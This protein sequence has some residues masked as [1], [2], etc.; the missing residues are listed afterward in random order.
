M[1]KFILGF[2]LFFLFFSRNPTGLTQEKLPPIL[3]LPPSVPFEILSPVGA[4]KNTVEEARL[5]MQREA[6]KVN[7]EAIISVHCKPGGIK[8]QALTWQ[9]IDAYCQ[10]KAIR[11]LK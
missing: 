11:Y 4:G 2:F 8:R 1:N 6:K 10:G 9:N 5:Q 7:A 3:E